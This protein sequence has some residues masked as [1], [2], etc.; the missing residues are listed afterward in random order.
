MSYKDQRE[1]TINIKPGRIVSM[2]AADYKHMLDAY[3]SLLDACSALLQAYAPKA[4]ETI[5]KH[6]RDFMHESVLKAVD[7]LAKAKGE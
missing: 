1:I 7:A 6:G 3:F 4:Q 2:D 5:D